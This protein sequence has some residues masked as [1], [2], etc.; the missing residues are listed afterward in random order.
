MTR[1]YTNAPEAYD[2]GYTTQVGV[3]PC[4]C[5]LRV[6]EVLKPYDQYQID[7]YM[8]GMYFAGEVTRCRTGST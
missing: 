1:V 3:C 5:G 6:V 7:R 4:G 8:S 2:Y